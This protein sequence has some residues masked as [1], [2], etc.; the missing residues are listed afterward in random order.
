MSILQI[1][2]W[3]IYFQ[4]FV[5]VQLLHMNGLVRLLFTVSHTYTAWKVSKYGV[6]SGP[7]FLVFGLNTEIYGVFGH[8][9]RSVIDLIMSFFKRMG[10]IIIWSGSLHFAKHFLI[11]CTINYIAIS[12]WHK[13]KILRFKEHL[14][15]Y[16]GVRYREGLCWH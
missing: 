2:L 1:L 14:K 11:G 5:P 8:F 13:L 7:Y 10:E 4:Y 6:I 9:S 3:S 16:I 12:L 15:G